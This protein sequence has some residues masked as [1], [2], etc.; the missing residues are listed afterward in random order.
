MARA[1]ADYHMTGPELKQLLQEKK[2]TP[3]TY[4]RH[5]REKY[6]LQYRF[7]VHAAR[8]IARI[9]KDLNKA[10]FPLRQVRQIWVIW[11]DSSYWEIEI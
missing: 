6:I 2:I 7:G 10:G 11:P 3:P 1:K 5:R 8:R 4:V 9:I